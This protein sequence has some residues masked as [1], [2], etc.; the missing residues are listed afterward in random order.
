[1]RLFRA[2]TISLENQAGEPSRLRLGG[3]GSLAVCSDLPLLLHC[4]VVVDRLMISVVWPNHRVMPDEIARTHNDEPYQ[5]L[6]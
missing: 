5:T 2:G 3:P 1:M 4:P 6:C